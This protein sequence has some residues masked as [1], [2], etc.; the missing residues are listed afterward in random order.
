LNRWRKQG[1]N[2]RESNITSKITKSLSG[3]ESD[4]DLTVK[5]LKFIQLKICIPTA[6]ALITFNGCAIICTQG[7][8]IVK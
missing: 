4:V 8:A 2:L 7:R 1:R 3:I 5:Y 6:A